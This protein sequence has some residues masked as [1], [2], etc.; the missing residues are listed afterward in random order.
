MPKGGP[1]GGDGAPGGDV[2]LVASRQFHDLSHFRHKHHFRGG[3]RRQR[4][5]RQPPRRR[6]AAAPYRGARR[7]RG[8]RSRGPVCSADLVVEGQEVLVA[9]GGEGGRGNVRFK[10]STRQTPRF[11]EHGSARRRTL[12]HPH[13]QT[14]RRRGARRP[15]QRGQVVAAGGAHEGEGPRSPPTRSPRSSPTWVCSGSPSVRPC[16]PTSPASSRAPAKVPAWATG[17]WRTSS[18]RRC[19]CTS[20]TVARSRRSGLP[21]STPCAPS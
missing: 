1:D 3:G 21:R 2:V 9:R 13:A 18:A 10:S 17:S 16:W 20:S 7:H 19:S 15:A 6:R 11:A 4:S 12:A 5:R 14:A 8:T